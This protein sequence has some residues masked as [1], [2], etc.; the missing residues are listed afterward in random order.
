MEG[1]VKDDQKKYWRGYRNKKWNVLDRD[2]IGG[3]W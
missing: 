3:K 1:V 2:N